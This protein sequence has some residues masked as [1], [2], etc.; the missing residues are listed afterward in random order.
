[1]A[2]VE[3]KVYI[4]FF[5]NT[6]TAPTGAQWL[7]VGTDMATRAGTLAQRLKQYGPIRDVSQYYLSFTKLSVNNRRALLVIE[8][9]PDDVDNAVTII[10]SIAATRGITG[11]AVQKAQG[12]LTKEIQEAAVRQG[13][14]GAQAALVTCENVVA[15][16]DRTAAIS[17]VQTYLANNNAAWHT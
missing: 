10:N 8:I 7:A 17:A 2:T 14:S 16:T 6:T 3:V 5:A 1:M 11:T 4:V 15:W 13:F 12:I 9:H